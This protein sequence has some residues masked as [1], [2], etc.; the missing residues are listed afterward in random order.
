MP[1]AGKALRRSSPDVYTLPS[2]ARISKLAPFFAIVSETRPGFSGRAHGAPYRRMTE[3]G[4]VPF[5]CHSLR[6]AL[7]REP[8]SGTKEPRRA[9]KHVPLITQHSAD[10]RSLR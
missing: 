3:K 9:Q 6:C 1:F 8:V 10:T 5:V 4:R 7:R 2:F